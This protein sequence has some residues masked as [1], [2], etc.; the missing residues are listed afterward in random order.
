MLRE[1]LSRIISLT[2]G[3]LKAVQRRIQMT[4]SESACH[5]D[6]ITA[7]EDEQHY[8]DIGKSKRVGF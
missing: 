6:V 8:K 7:L 5:E 1:R 3:D 4:A 2:P